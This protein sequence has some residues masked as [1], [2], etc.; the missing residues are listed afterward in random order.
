MVPKEARALEGG[1]RLCPA[2]KLGNAETTVSALLPNRQLGKTRVWIGNTRV[3][4]RAR[5]HT[6]SAA[7]RGE[8]GPMKLRPSVFGTSA[9]VPWTSQRTFA[10]VRPP[11]NVIRAL[12]PMRKAPMMRKTADRI[13]ESGDRGNPR[14]PDKD[15]SVF[16]LT[17]HGG[18]TAARGA[19]AQPTRSRPHALTSV[20]TSRTAGSAVSD[21]GPVAS[22]SV[23]LFFFADEKLV[24]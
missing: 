12:L 7:F 16:R 3:R 23:R 19:K 14:S 6:M 9:L 5:S 4:K 10:S 15:Q 20:H 1:G 24:V 13:S 21:Y 18:N 8:D 22:N 11:A 2:C 17:T